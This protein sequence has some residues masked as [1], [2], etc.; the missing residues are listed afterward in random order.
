MGLYALAGLSKCVDEFS[1]T[2]TVLCTKRV[3]SALFTFYG[4]SE[5]YYVLI[6][7]YDISTYSLVV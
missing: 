2:C 4:F 3:E 6:H 7:T 1:A 5:S